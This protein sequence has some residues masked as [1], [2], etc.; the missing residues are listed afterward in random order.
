MGH[1]YEYEHLGADVPDVSSET[2]AEHLAHIDAGETLHVNIR[3]IRVSGEDRREQPVPRRY[4]QGDVLLSREELRERLGR[5]D[6]DVRPWPP[7]PFDWQEMAATAGR[8]EPPRRSLRQ[9]IRSAFR[10]SW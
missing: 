2:A 5:R 4:R 1:S 9:R 7:L 10:W 3:R 8:E 6:I